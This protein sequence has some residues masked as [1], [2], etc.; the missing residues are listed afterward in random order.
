LRAEVCVRFI[1]GL[2]SYVE[3]TRDLDRLGLVQPRA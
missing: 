2:L 3:A 1:K